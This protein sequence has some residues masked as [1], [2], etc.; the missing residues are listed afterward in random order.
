M[1]SSRIYGMINI[2]IHHG[3]IDQ[4]A[5]KYFYRVREINLSE[6]CQPEHASWNCNKS[7]GTSRFSVLLYSSQNSCQSQPSIKPEIDKL[8]IIGNE[9]FAHLPHASFLDNE[10]QTLLADVK[11]TF[12]SLR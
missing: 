4:P 10:H 8:R 6:N 3:T 2:Q 1:V 5:G 7:D 11:A 12:I 9:C